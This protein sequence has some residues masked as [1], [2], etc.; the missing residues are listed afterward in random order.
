MIFYVGACHLVWLHLDGALLWFSLCFVESYPS[1]N[2]GCRCHPSGLNI[3]FALWRFKLLC[4]ETLISTE[5]EVG[6]C[7]WG[8]STP[9]SREPQRSALSTS[10]MR[11][12]MAFFGFPRHGYP[13][14]I[15]SFYADHCWFIETNISSA[16]LDSQGLLHMRSSIEVGSTCPFYPVNC[17][18]WIANETR[19]STISLSGSFENGKLLL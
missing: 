16:S 6:T 18:L 15:E 1:I 19:K 3:L 7:Q 12:P 14:T 10:L 4:K 17:L 2:A 5:T 9:P 8:L 13:P 11:W